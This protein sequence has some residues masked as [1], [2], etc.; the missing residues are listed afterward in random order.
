M[1]MLFAIKECCFAQKKDGALRFCIDF[2]ELNPNTIQDLSG[3][4]NAINKLIGS[5]FLLKLDFWQVDLKEKDEDECKPA[6]TF[7][8]IVVGSTNAPG[9]LTSG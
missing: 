6:L 4:G 9:K 8:R 2:R 7:N 3:T 5:R 1:P